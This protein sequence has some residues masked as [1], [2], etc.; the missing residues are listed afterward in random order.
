MLPHVSCEIGHEAEDSEAV[1][2]FSHVLTCGKGVNG[3]E[4]DRFR[5]EGPEQHAQ[6][7]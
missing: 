2:R 6:G 3:A 7:Q 4:F 5:V 1:L